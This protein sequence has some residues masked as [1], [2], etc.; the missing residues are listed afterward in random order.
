MLIKICG[1]KF[2]ANMHEMATLNMDIMGF[3][4]YNKSPRYVGD[5]FD[6]TLLES[7]PKSM[8]K[9]GVFV[10]EDVMNVL[11]IVKNYN[12]DM[13]QLHGNESAEYCENLKA[14]GISI[15][16]AFQIDDDFDFKILR[17]Y[18]GCCDYFL[19]D[20]KGKEKGGNGIAFNWEVLNQYELDTPYFLSGGISV[21]NIDH[22]LTI[23]HP[24]LIGFDINSKIEIEPGLKSHELAHKITT[25]I[26]QH[27][28][29][30][31]R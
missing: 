3:I 25:K 27:E 5:H 12:L 24:Q 30:K 22:A 26:K 15:I 20:T 13:V 21:E 1:M 28:E 9:A 2:P 7:L 31:T 8:R 18:Q 19:F 16:K 17:T 14:D 11:Q 4:F 29:H 23:V 10:D 6:K